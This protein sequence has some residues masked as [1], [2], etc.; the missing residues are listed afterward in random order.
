MEFI[1]LI[2]LSFH[3]FA[4]D[5]AYNKQRASNYKFNY[6]KNCLWLILSN[7]TSIRDNVLSKL[8][9]P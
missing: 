5:K 4:N 6:R 9:D 3:N 1:I 8:V 2:L 7:E